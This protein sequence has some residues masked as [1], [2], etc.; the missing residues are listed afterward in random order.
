ME[1]IVT[2][3]VAKLCGCAVAEGTPWDPSRYEVEIT[4]AVDYRPAGSTKM[5]YAKEAGQYAAKLKFPEPGTYTFT[6]TAFDPVPK[7][8]GT[9]TTTVI[10]AAP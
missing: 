2:A 7:E 9:D 10:L 3:N 1:I 4:T 8:G 5:T 6:V